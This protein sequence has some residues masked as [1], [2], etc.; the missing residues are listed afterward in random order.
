MLAHE[1][2]RNV[3][4]KTLNSKKYAHLKQEVLT[5]HSLVGLIDKN[6][7]D[8][9]NQ[10]YRN[11]VQMEFLKELSQDKKLISTFVVLKGMSFSEYDI[12]ESLGDRF[13]ADIDLL[14]QDLD[15]FS[16]LLASREFALVNN[17]KW[18]G[19]DFKRVYSRMLN[20]IEVVVELHTRLFYHTKFNQYNIVI[21]RNGFGVLALEDLLVHLVGHLAFQHTFLKIHWLM[22][23]YFI[24]EIKKDNL[25]MERV[26]YLLKKLELN[27]SW[28][29]TMRFVDVFFREKPSANIL[30]RFI[31]DVDFLLFPEKHRFKYYLIKH[32]TKDNALTSFSYNYHWLLEKGWKK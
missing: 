24:L 31:Y 15:A 12:Y 9:K 27:K 8:W 30:E 11:T 2:A 28:C 23:I 18:K 22:D 26:W 29:M 3:L 7:K 5:Q 17:H 21:S 6:S 19:N 20:G 10:Y 13:T 14:V 25:D 16:R 4:L 1:N 32:L